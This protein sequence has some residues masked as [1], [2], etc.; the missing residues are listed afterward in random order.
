MLQ[1][2]SLAEERLTSL[3]DCNTTATPA[4]AAAAS[5]QLSAVYRRKVSVLCCKHVTRV[6]Q[7]KYILCMYACLLPLSGEAISAS[8]ISHMLVFT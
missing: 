1:I 7:L 4:A 6:K 3:S 2:L 8:G 5:C